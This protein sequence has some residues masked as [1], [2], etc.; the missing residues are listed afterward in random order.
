MTFADSGSVSLNCMP[1][2]LVEIAPNGPRNCETASGFG[3]HV[4]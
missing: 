2:A 4:S 1:G 3:S